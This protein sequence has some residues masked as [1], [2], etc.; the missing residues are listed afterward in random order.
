[1]VNHF[2][3]HSPIVDQ[4]TLCQKKSFIAPENGAP[5]CSRERVVLDR[6]H[7][8]ALHSFITLLPEEDQDDWISWC[9]Y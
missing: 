7:H 3:R 9:R 5:K 1:M 6:Q 4:L 2:H 8:D